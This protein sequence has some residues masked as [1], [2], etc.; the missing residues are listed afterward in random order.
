MQILN[1]I[2]NLVSDVLGAVSMLFLAFLMLGITL[3]VIVR[4]VIGRPISGVFEFTE[5]ALV[6][7]VFLGAGWAQRGDSHIRVTVLIDKLPNTTRSRV[8][9]IGWAMGAL[10]LLLLAIPSTSEA[11]YSISIWEFRWGQVKIPIWWVKASLAA[12][13]WFAFIQ[14]AVQSIQCF[15]FGEPEQQTRAKA[16]I[17]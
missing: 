8:V 17:T 15:F 14:M 4:A 16:G 11:I 3:D 13:L 6:M 12:G 5:I 10:A 9:G 2:L 7:M 1:R